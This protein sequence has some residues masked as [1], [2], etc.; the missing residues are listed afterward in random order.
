[1]VQT[2]FRKKGKRLDNTP[3]LPPCTSLFNYVKIITMIFMEITE[4]GSY[5]Y[6]IA[7]AFFVRQ[8]DR[9]HIKNIVPG[10]GVTS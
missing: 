10:A 8:V 7:A 9:W 4:G 2:Q 6:R 1:M 3:D 5:R